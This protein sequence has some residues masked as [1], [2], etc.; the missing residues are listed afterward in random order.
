VLAA[1]D[2]TANP[3]AVTNAG[4][5]TERW[6][7][8]FT[9]NTD[10]YLAGEAVGQIITG[11]TATTL[12]PVNPATGE[13]YFTLQPAGWGS[14]WAAGNVYR[15]NTAGANFP[16]WV[17]RTVLQSP[18]APPGTDQTTISILGDIDQ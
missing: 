6:A 7:I 13:A 14:G 8:I 4:A 12:A 18:S 16:L 17:A 9:S 1:Y 15:F 3:I 5:I 10:F 11:N 2:Q